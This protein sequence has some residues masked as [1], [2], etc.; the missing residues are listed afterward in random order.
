M[1]F[2]HFNL[3]AGF[4]DRAGL[5]RVS[6]L[7]L[8]LLSLSPDYLL[9]DA[10]GG[11][12]RFSAVMRSMVK[13]VFVADSSLGMN[14]RAVDKGLPTVCAQAESLP[15]SSSSFERVIMVDA[16]HH[17]L[18][19][20]QSA[21]ELFRVLVPGGRI[22]I[23]EPDI[24]RFIVRVLAIGEKVL[25]MRSH[26]LSGDKIAGLFTD[27]EAKTSIYYEGFNVISIAEKVR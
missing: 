13:G 14:Q 15:F 11:T 19:Q 24:H 17:V 27:P 26:F 18:D 2:D 25:L 12:G 20:R 4:Y 16:L 5:F 7:L 9:L 23:V 6:E 10:G 21:C 22:V 8:E 3:I 1:P